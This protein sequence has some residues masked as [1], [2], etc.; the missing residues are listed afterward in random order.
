MEIFK[1]T[2]ALDLLYTMQN[3]Q[4]NYWLFL[5]TVVL[6][7]VAYMGTDNVFKNNRLI[8]VTTYLFFQL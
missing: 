1:L 8:L 5:I 3:H 2:D 7:I 6:S 4:S